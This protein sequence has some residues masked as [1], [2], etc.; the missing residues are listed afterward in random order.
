MDENQGLADFLLFWFDASV[1]A[2]RRLAGAAK[3]A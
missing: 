1:V 2:V 3:T